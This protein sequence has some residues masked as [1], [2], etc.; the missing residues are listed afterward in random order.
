MLLLLLLLL[1][2]GVPPRARSA[3]EAESGPVRP[4]RQALTRLDPALLHSL[5]PMVWP[6]A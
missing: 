6:A 4:L 2:L 5:A 1:G 3:P